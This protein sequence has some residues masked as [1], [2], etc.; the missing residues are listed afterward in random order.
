MSRGAVAAGLALVTLVMF[1]HAAWGN[2]ILPAE[3]FPARV[4]GTVSGLGGAGKKQC[5]RTP[6]GP[7]KGLSSP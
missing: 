2:V 4:V 3:L 7:S 6:P 5:A 1:G